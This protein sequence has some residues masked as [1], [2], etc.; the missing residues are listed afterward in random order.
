M[1]AP[2]YLSDDFADNEL[3]HRRGAEAAADS[4]RK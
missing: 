3:F 4:L 1:D 2:D